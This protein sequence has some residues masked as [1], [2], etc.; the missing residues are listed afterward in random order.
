MTNKERGLLLANN[1]SKQLSKG[2]R[3]YYTSY[4]VNGRWHVFTPA[5]Y[6]EEL[7]KTIPQPTSAY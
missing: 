1:V 4:F 2:R 7:E 5:Q 3:I 6:R